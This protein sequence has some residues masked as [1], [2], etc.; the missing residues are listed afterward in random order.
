VSGSFRRGL[1]ALTLAGLAVRLLW[2][3]LEPATHP[4]ADETMWVAWGS[5]ILPSPDVAFSPLRL[6]FVFHPPLYLY[7]VGV[8]STLFGSLE[9]VKYAQCLAGALLVPALG[10]LGRRAFGERAAL[11]AAGIA[12]FYPEL[13]WFASHF[14]AETVFTVLLWWAM[15]R[16]LAADGEGGG[17]AALVSGLLWGLAVLTRE[18]VLYFLPL[19]ALWLAWRRAGGARRAAMLLSVAA[20]VVLPWTVRNWLVFDAFV[21]VSTAGALNLWQGNTRL[22]RQEVY[23]EYWAVRGRIE[24][25]EHSR[26]RAVEVILERQPL[27]LFEKLRDEMPAFWA[28]HGQPIVHLERG[29][30]GVVARPR[31]LL[32]VAVVLLP[33]LALLVLFVAGIAALPRGRAPVLLLGFLAFYVLL[34]VAAHGYPRYR[35]PAL[36]ALFLVAAQGWACRPW[37]KAREGCPRPDRARRLAAAAV[38]LAL[39]LSV[40]P[41]LAGWATQPWPPPWFAGAGVEGGPEAPPRGETPQPEAP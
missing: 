7:F 38:A 27:W 35:L 25:Y 6:R 1:L 13:V 21:P 20:L 30:Y 18:T 34:H 8:P 31:A 15:E 26:R 5:R 28:A 39:G 10:L 32:A 29:A 23:D 36:P 14:W 3:V 24:K 33:Y 37:L 9:A 12:A 22:S 17:R 41:S 40:G 4:V 16:L 19:A 11:V 2:V